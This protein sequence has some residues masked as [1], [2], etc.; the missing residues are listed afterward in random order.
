[1]YENSVAFGSILNEKGEDASINYNLTGT[2][3]IK[4]DPATLTVY[5]K[6]IH[7]TYSDVDGVRNALLNDYYVKGEAN[8]DSNPALR[9]SVTLT[10]TSNAIVKKNGV[11][12]TADASTEGYAINTTDASTSN[13]NYRLVLGD[14]GKSILTRL[15]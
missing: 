15:T 12:R 4:V 2:G 8:G 9:D 1:M 5:T 13:G 6:D 14:A 3:T 11:D 7:K 10:N